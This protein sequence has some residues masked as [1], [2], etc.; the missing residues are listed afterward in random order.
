MWVIFLL[1]IQSFVGSMVGW[2][3]KSAFV[4]LQQFHTLAT[5]FIHTSMLPLLFVGSTHAVYGD[6]IKCT[7]RSLGTCVSFFSRLHKLPN[8]VDDGGCWSCGTNCD[9]VALSG[10][11]QMCYLFYWFNYRSHATNHSDRELVKYDSLFIP[12]W[13]FASKFHLIW[14]R[15]PIH[16]LSVIMKMVSALIQMVLR[17]ENQKL[18]LIKLKKNTSKHVARR[19]RSPATTFLENLRQFVGRW[20]QRKR[21]VWV[22][23]YCENMEN[24]SGSNHNHPACHVWV[25]VCVCCDKRSRWTAN[26]SRNVFWWV[27]LVCVADC[28]LHEMLSPWKFHEEWVLKIVPK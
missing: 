28:G 8:H 25:N 27:G 13:S 20:W 4:V 7:T 3:F 19:Q 22:N 2:S 5:Q 23:T 14:S 24:Q 6:R 17:H 18:T 15:Y 21:P 12:L 9:I 10:C 16:K 11:V 26:N 1:F